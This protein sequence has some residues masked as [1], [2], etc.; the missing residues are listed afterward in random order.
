MAPL[1]PNVHPREGS[2]GSSAREVNSH[3]RHMPC[4]SLLN[5]GGGGLATPKNEPESIQQL[6]PTKDP[7]APFQAPAHRALAHDPAWVKRAAREAPFL[8]KRLAAPFPCGASPLLGGRRSFCV[9]RCP[10]LTWPPREG[11]REQPPCPPL[12]ALAFSL[13]PGWR[14]VRLQPREWALW[15]LCGTTQ[16]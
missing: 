9:W 2:R 7:E 13:S 1:G 8:S 5:G 15:G 4:L 10:S 3:R 6:L 14:G 12:A 16:Q 11:P